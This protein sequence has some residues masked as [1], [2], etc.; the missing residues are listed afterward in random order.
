MIILIVSGDVYFFFR[1]KERYIIAKENGI[2]RNQF[3]EPKVY[4]F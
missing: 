4:Q 3:G 1:S 2:F